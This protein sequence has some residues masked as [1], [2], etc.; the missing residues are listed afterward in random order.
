MEAFES[1]FGFEPPPSVEEIKLKNFFLYDA[2]T[3]WMSFTYDSIVFE[4]ILLH[5]Q[6]LLIAIPNTSEHAEIISELAKENP[7]TPD[8]SIAPFSGTDKI[9]YK[10]DFLDHT[11]SEYYLWRSNDMVHLMVHYFD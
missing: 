4:K 7:N 3:H 9:Y 5:D 10:R 2:S 8:W 11:L 6:P 1:N